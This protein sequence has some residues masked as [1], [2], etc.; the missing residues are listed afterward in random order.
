MADN[1]R[2][3]TITLDR[4]V[5][6]GPLARQQMWN[7]LSGA[8]NTSVQELE[9]RYVSKRYNQLQ[10]V[11]LKEDVSEDLAIFLRERSEDY[12]GIDIV[13]NWRREYPYAP[14][15]SHVLGFLGAIR[16]SE[17]TYYKNLGY[18]PD[19]R[20][21]QFGVEQ[22]YESVLRG[23]SGYVKYEVDSRGRILRL[24]ERKEPIPGN[25]LQLSINLDIQQFTEQALQNELL[26][27]RRTEAPTVL[28][29]GQPDPAYPEI[30][31][32]KAPAGSSVVL[33]H[34]TGEVVAMASYPNFDNRWFNAGITSEKFAE[35][36]PTTKDPD[37]SILVN[38]AISGR[39]NLG[40]AFK[41]F[42]AFA[43]LNSGQLA[44]G[45]KYTLK[46]E[47]TYKL[48]SIP[49]ERCQLNVKCIFKNAV[50]GNGAPCKY[51]R[52]NVVSAIAVSSDVFF[53]KIGE[54]IFTQRGNRP[55]LEEQ[56]RLFGFGS[57]TEIDLPYEF[58][59]TIPSKALKQRLAASGAI[60]KD[61]GKG[62]YVG[63]N[64]QFAI[65]QG[66]LSATP[67]QLAVA[68]GT[69]ANGGKVMR[70]RVVHAILAPGTPNGKSGHVNLAKSIVLQSFAEP[71]VVRDIDARPEV[72]D[73]IIRGLTRVVE[74][75]GVRSDIYHSTTGE[76]LF[77][78]YPSRSL[79]IAGKTG[80][81]QGAGNLPWNDSSVFG[82][83]SKDPKQPY[84][85]VAYLEKSGYGSR[86]AAPVVKCVFTALAGKTTV[87][88]AVPADPLDTASF[89]VA[90][91]QLL[92]NP[93]CL[94]GI[95]S[96]VR[97]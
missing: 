2:L 57:P 77:R 83:F 96:S 48:E 5:I 97:D 90:S 20:V 32:Y 26:V 78:S 47:G 51:G 33:N 75:P 85:I 19:A 62:F 65:G 11:P 38:R 23:K 84:S 36:F 28:S 41:P 45:T 79:P 59:G 40:S 87:A 14:M 93:L 81:A 30:T 39:Y 8:L 72:I 43:A 18:D 73:P 1:E 69:L 86:A 66:L 15:A 17:T 35:L 27:R 91:P 37:Q 25:D 89:A 95:G 54:Q 53:Y 61:E 50:C 29:F 67:L 82:A 44:G 88:K 76:K 80:T 34:E 24:I 10:P 52:I 12:P 58:I 16:K 22:T 63:D 60:A 56:V 68:Y 74:G 92:P 42:V 49:K 31:Y 70:P 3:L 71:Q 4:A 21:G 46:D 55:V 13:E 94:V 7:R 64:V 9:D 6:A